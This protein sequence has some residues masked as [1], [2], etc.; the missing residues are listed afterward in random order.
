MANCVVRDNVYIYIMDKKIEN[1]SKIVHAVVGPE[2]TGDSSAP[3]RAE[4]GV[5]HVLD[6][7]A[8]SGTH[9][10]PLPLSSRHMCFHIPP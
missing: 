3:S 5:H 6:S 8:F 4:H 2:S 9:A 1:D 7:A 10:T